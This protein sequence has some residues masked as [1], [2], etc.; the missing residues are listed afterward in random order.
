MSFPVFVL[1]LFFFPSYFSNL[2]QCLNLYKNQNP[3]KQHHSA[4]TRIAHSELHWDGLLVGTLWW[5]F[6]GSFVLPL[7][8]SGIAFF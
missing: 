5:A 2:Q 6:L 3:I 7:H 4:K 8:Q 1:L